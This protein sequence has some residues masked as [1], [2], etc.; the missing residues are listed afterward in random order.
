MNFNLTD[1]QRLLQDSVRRFVEKDYAFEARTARVKSGE[2]CER[3]HWA[4]F[5]NNGWLAAALPEAAAGWAAP[6]STPC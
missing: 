4:T 1:E 6:S 3:R 2:P 5:A